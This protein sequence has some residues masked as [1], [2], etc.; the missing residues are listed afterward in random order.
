MKT[1]DTGARTFGMYSGWKSL[2]QIVSRWLDRERELLSLRNA[3]GMMSEARRNDAA[4]YDQMYQALR[5]A[6]ADSRR[7]HWLTEDHS[8][9]EVRA[10][11]RRILESMAVRSYSGTCLDI[12]AAMEGLPHES[13]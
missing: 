3:V 5:A 9:P 2:R 10:Q 13:R 12:D 8:D 11:C 4:E 7:L 6:R 1:Y